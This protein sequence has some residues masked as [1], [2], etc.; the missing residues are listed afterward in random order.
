LGIGILAVNLQALSTITNTIIIALA[1][2]A[3]IWQLRK[4]MAQ[5]RLQVFMNYTERY[6]KI[7]VTI[8]EAAFDP[9][10]SIFMIQTVSKEIKDEYLTAMRQYFNMC[11]EEFYLHQ[12]RLLD[13]K[14]WRLWEKGIKFAMKLPSYQDAW[15]IIR[16]HEGYDEAFKK[17]VDQFTKKKSS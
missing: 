14:V 13:K 15:E 2:L 8:P 12:N 11:S 5:I 16:G 10:K 17:L 4:F 6:S 1:A 7:I 9:E 3:A